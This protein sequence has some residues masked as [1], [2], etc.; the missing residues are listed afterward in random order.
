MR[1]VICVDVADDH[2]FIWS[3]EIKMYFWGVF[4][5][6]KGSLSHQKHTGP[7]VHMDGETVKCTS[8]TIRFFFMLMF[9]FN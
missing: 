1:C 9:A 8:S 6:F 3:E 7:K 5:I 2:T 4:S